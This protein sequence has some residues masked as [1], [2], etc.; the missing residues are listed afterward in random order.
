MR[1]ILCGL[2]LTPL[3]LP[4]WAGRI[5]DSPERARELDRQCEA[6]RTELLK[7]IQEEKIRECIGEGREEAWCRRHFRG[8]GWGAVVGGNRMARF[9][10]DLPVCVEALELRK[11]IQ[12]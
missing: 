7:P 6:H 5:D 2:M 12:P 10:E 3:G 11:R 8:Y 1:F 4:A 9:Y